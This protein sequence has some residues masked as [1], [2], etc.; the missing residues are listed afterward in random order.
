MDDAT[1][2][3]LTRRLKVHVTRRA[4]LRLMPGLGLLVSALPSMRIAPPVLAKKHKKH[5]KRK[6]K[7]KGTRC[8]EGQTICE[9][10][11]IAS[12]ACCTSV[13][14]SGGKICQDQACICS[15]E[16]PG[17]PQ[18]STESCCAPPPGLPVTRV[19][20]G[21]I[22]R[23]A[24]CVCEFHPAIVCGVGCSS[25]QLIVTDCTTVGRENLDDAC[26]DIGC[27]PPS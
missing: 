22:G 27:E 13:E 15:A 1:F 20:C 24:A 19:S 9:G 18:V 6:K 12:T 11:C 23:S 14:C 7:P 2:D 26:L 5:K 3:A 10:A 21:S 4:V 25:S 8:Q 16:R 17:C